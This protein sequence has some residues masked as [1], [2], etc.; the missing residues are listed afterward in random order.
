MHTAD[1]DTIPL[2]GWFFR[3]MRGIFSLPSLI[4]MT[5]FVGFSA[6]ALESGVARGEAV[7]MTLVIWALPAKMILIGSM[8]GG[9]NLAA[10][11]LAVTLSSVRMMPM[12]ASIVP[13]MRGAKTPTWILLFLSHFVAIT[14]WVFATQNLSKVPREA[15]AA[16]FAGFGITLT[17]V[18]AVIVGL[19]YGIVAA[20]P[21]LVA[22]VLFFL[23]PVYFVA[24]IWAS[25]RHSVVKVAFVIGV[26]AGPAFAVIAPEFDILYAGIG[27]GTAAY[28]IDRLV[29]RRRIK[30]VSP[31][32]EP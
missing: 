13:E 27:G 17:V 31:E 5:S 19:C 7:F 15:R 22:G 20:F 32:S 11:F 10:C 24:S 2:R 4:L 18:N 28:L 9:A 25:A 8:V 16:W 1:S 3:G 14:A 29:F 23:T 12:V 30:P 21:P 6:F 26:I